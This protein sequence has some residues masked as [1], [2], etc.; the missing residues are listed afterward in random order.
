MGGVRYYLYNTISYTQ[1]HKHKVG[2][3]LLFGGGNFQNERIEKWITFRQQREQSKQGQQQQ[4][5]GYFGLFAEITEISLWI[6]LESLSVRSMKS[7]TLE[8]SAI[9]SA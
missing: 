5:R 9:F 1:S 3:Y 8:P 4:A 6:F 2:I 7:S